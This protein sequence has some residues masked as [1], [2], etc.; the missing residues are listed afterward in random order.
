LAPAATLF[1]SG[2]LQSISAAPQQASLLA[3]GF[4]VAPVLLHY[5]LGFHDLDSR[6]RCILPAGARVERKNL[7][8]TPAQR[9][10]VTGIVNLLLQTRAFPLIVFNGRDG[11]GRSTAAEVVCGELGIPLLR[12]DLTALRA[13]AEGFD[14]ALQAILLQQRLQSASLYLERGEALFDEQGR[15][16]PGSRQVI[17]SLAQSRNP[18]FI[19]CESSLRFVE[20]ACGILW[21]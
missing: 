14:K 3:S 4:W 10:A 11:S 15:P 12:V 16:L 2:L 1:S 18:T 21:F 17:K 5:L 6:V 20:S 9:A 19:A 8:L 7:L 13:S